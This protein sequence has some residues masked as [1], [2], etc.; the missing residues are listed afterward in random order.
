LIP[1]PRSA[2]RELLASLRDPY[3][4]FVPPPDFA[5]MAKYDVSGV[6]LNL[7]TAEEFANKTVRSWGTAAAPRCVRQALFQAPGTVLLRC[8]ICSLVHRAIEDAA[9]GM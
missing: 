6:G 2:I 9:A 1:C 3:T 8:W 5:A 4:R 7:G